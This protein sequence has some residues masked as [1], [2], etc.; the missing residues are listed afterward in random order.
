MLSLFV[1]LGSDTIISLIK[2]F[3]IQ[4]YIFLAFTFILIAFRVIR[5]KTG[6]KYSSSIIVYPLIYLFLT[7][8]SSIT[9]TLNQFEFSM[10]VYLIG[11][12][13]GFVIGDLSVFK[14]RKGE[15]IYESS[16]TV[17]LAWSLLFLVKWYTYLY[18]QNYPSLFDPVITICFTLLAGIL[19]GEAFGIIFKHRIS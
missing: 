15:E 1:A 8:Y 16:A 10:I 14:T 19:L 17:A 3:K 7:L 12:I 2:A 18:G 9:L 13:S 6:K 4:F 11:F 5:V